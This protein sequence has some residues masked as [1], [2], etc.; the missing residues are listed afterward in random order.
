MKGYMNMRTEMNPVF[1]TS[2]PLPELGRPLSAESGVFE[3]QVV[4]RVDPALSSIARQGVNLRAA[5]SGPRM[6]NKRSIPVT[7][8]TGPNPSS[9]NRLREVLAIKLIRLVRGT[10]R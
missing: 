3:V 6:S 9:K 1:K 2:Q 10:I 7:R 5:L 8:R 4:K